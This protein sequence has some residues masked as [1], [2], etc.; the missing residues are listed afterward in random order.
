M[1]GYYYG[2]CSKYLK[3]NSL[4]G[5]VEYLL[6]N[7]ARMNEDLCGI[8]GKNFKNYNYVDTNNTIIFNDIY[9]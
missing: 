4:S 2:K 9:E 5:E 6:A 3:Q 8:N 1:I 7:E